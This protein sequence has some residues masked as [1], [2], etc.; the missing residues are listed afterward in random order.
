MTE[1]QTVDTEAVGVKAEESQFSTIRFSD[2]DLAPSLK[3]G[4][5]DA[6]FEFCTPIQAKSLQRTRCRVIR[7]MLACTGL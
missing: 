5:I 6:G 4:V 2:L 3:Q 7:D 1:L